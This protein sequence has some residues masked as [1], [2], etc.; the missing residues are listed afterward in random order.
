M[1]KPWFLIEGK[2]VVVLIKPSSW[3]SQ[4]DSYLQYHTPPQQRFFWRRCQGLNYIFPRQLRA[5]K[6]TSK[7]SG[8]IAG[9][10]E[11]FCEGSFTHISFTFLLFCF[12]LFL[13]ASFYKKHT[14]N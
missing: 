2:L 12:S 14:K 9:E 3:G 4:L 5:S 6:M 11:N 7:F 13:L 1:I 10:K 8:A